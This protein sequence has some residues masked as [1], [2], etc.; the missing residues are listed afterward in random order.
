VAAAANGRRPCFQERPGRKDSKERTAEGSFAKHPCDDENHI[1]AKEAAVKYNGGDEP[2][3][4]RQ[5]REKKECFIH[6][7][8]RDGRLLKIGGGNFERGGA[9]GLSCAEGVKRKVWSSWESA[10]ANTVPPSCITILVFVL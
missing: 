4:G 9:L 5:R 7:G 10:N 8:R 6:D 2:A 3:N 1:R